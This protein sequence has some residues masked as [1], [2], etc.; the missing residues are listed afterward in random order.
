MWFCHH[1][2]HQDAL[3]VF[4]AMPLCH[5]S[6][7][8]LWYLFRHVPIMPWVLHRYVSFSEL[9][10]PPFCILYVW[11]PFWCLLSTF[12]CHAGC[13]IHPEGLNHSG[14]H[15]C[16]PL[17]FTHARHMGATWW[18]SLAHTR[19][20]QSGCSLHYI[21]LGEHYAAPS[22]VPQQSH[23]YDGAYSFG[24]LAESYPIP[25]PSLHGGEGSSFPGLVPSNDTVD[26]E[27]VMGVK[28]GDSG[29]VIGYQID[30]FTHTW[31]AEQVVA[32]F[33]IYPG[34]TGKV[35]SLTHFP[36]EPVCEDYSFWTRPWLTLNKAWIPPSLIPLR[37]QNWM[38][39]WMSL[40]PFHLQSLLGFFT[41]LVLFVI[42]LNCS[43]LLA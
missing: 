16:N 11:C 22:A 4:L 30:E 40:M 35:S 29:I 2:W 8:H 24:G 7:L 32:H 37:H 23:L 31:S 10:L 21:K 34:F 13:H 33:H 1:P 14:M 27:S 42:I 5:S 6:N 3:E 26:S 28:P 9:S 17:E 25:L 36:L 38:L 20:A 12:R 43:L 18:W 15:Y 41:W 39:P 19:Y